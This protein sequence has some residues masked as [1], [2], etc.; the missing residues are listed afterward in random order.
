MAKTINKISDDII[1][2]VESKTITKVEQFNKNVLLTEKKTHENKI[3]EID[4]L[5]TNF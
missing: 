2:I 4:D 3:V 1:E 5:L